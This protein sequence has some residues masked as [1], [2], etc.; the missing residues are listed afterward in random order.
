MTHFPVYASMHQ[1][2]PVHWNDHYKTWIV[3]GHDA[4]RS[5]L[6]DKRFSSETTELMRSTMFPIRSRDRFQPLID[7]FRQWLL[8]SDPPYHTMLRKILNPYFGPEALTALAPKKQCYI[9]D[10]L[11]SCQGEWDFMAAFASRLP[12]W[13]MSVVIGFPRED[14]PMILA[15]NKALSEFMEAVIRTPQI[16]EAALIA[17]QEQQRYFQHFQSELADQIPSDVRWPIL[18]MLLGAG[19]ETTQHLM[20]NGLYRLLS[21]PAQWQQLL[22]QPSLLGSAVEEC[23]R[24]DSPVQSIVR[25]A[26]ASAD[27]GGKTIGAGQYVR[28]MIGA[29]HHDP[30]RVDAP[31][32][33]NITRD[34]NQHIAFGAGLHFCIGQ[35]LAR[36]TAQEAFQALLIAYPTLRLVPER[37]QWIGGVS[38]RGLGQLKVTI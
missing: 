3:V 19:I 20:G 34:P 14:I 21:H 28:V 27:L 10:L 38:L 17:L 31:Q 23:L 35:A 5:L 1:Q 7:F 12:A 37:P 30:A 9:H 18:S 32:Q 26:T 36:Q 4:A 24:Y 11:S 33:F 15:W 29:I 22:E 16:N 13:I 2:G 6:R 8:F 25:V